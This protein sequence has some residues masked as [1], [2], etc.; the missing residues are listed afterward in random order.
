MGELQE[1]LLRER[2]LVYSS[3][4]FSAAREINVT[5]VRRHLRKACCA[6]DYALKCGEP[7]AIA[8]LEAEIRGYSEVL[9]E[10]LNKGEQ[11]C[12]DAPCERL[13]KGEVLDVTALRVAH[14]KLLAA[15]VNIEEYM[16]QYVVDLLD[17]RE[18]IAE[19]MAAIDGE[20]RVHS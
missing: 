10:R 4:R 5:E 8:R 7:W 16:K 2:S 15:S 18:M 14:A 12:A 17:V 11:G 20:M 13:N 1:K 3:A 6:Y 19:C 9:S